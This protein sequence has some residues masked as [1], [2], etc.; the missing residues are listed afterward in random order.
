[1][2]D[3]LEE[4]FSPERVLSDVEEGERPLVA[5]RTRLEPEEPEHMSVRRTAGEMYWRE[6]A[7]RRIE[8]ALTDAPLPV[9]RMESVSPVE[10][11]KLKAAPEE[12][13]TAEYHSAVIRRQDEERPEEMLE[14]RLRRDSRRYDSG[15]FWY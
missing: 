6:E 11:S 9:R 12:P 8:S 2:I 10:M 1:M 5:P 7:V 4:I 15:F 14:R 3:Y 13:G